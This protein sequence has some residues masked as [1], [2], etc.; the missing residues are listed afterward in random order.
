MKLKKRFLLA[1][2][3]YKLLKDK[4]DELMDRFVESADAV[5]KLRAVVEKLYGGL[6]LPYFIARSFSGNRAFMSLCSNPRVKMVISGVKERVMNLIIPMLKV[7]FSDR[8]DSL[9]NLDISSLLPGLLKKF[10]ALAKDI[11]NLAN[12]ERRMFLIAGELEKV[13]R[14]VNALE[15]I[16]LP[17]LEETIEYISMQLEEM[18]REDIVRLM[19]VKDIVRSH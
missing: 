6:K 15:Y 10:I 11:I 5:R 3:G 9:G 12:E 16:F 8:L 13:R 14:R 4:Q 19:K 2:R 17:K 1:K 7:D 18:E